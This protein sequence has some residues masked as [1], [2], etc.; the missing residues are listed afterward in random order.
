MK[1]KAAKRRPGPL[2]RP[3]DDGSRSGVEIWRVIDGVELCQW[4]RWLLRLALAEIDGLAALATRFK[5][6]RGEEALLLQLKDLQRRLALLKRTPGGVLDPIERH[7]D[8]L[9]KKAAKRVFEDGPHSKTPV[10]IATP[11]KVL[12]ERA[13]RGHWD[14]FPI[15]PAAFAAVLERETAGDYTYRTTNVFVS[16]VERFV[17]LAT[18]AAG[19]AAR[20]A[21]RRAAMTVVIEAM[22]RV[23]DSLAE[24]S[25]MFREIEHAYLEDLLAF[26]GV[27]GLLR[28]L[29]EL[30]IWEDY[31]LIEGVDQFLRG[32]PVEHGEPAYAAL[33]DVAAELEREGLRN[34]LR[35]ARELAK[36]LGGSLADEG[37]GV[38]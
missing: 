33:V 2:D 27:D 7:S 34:Q 21:T 3:L 8:W 30:A 9:L 1:P 14:R 5:G 29:I 37:N 18:T 10:M 28:D 13:L 20:L 36:A 17:S 15:S 35:A 12:S 22:D 6:C 32:L 11:R 16:A 31:G 26:A 24:V 4:D 25:T 19:S 38:R 23:D